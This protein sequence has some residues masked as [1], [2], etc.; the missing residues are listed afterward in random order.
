MSTSEA[1][2]VAMSYGVREGVWIQRLLNKLL[3]DQAIRR[4]EMLGDQKTHLTLTRDPESQNCTKHIDVIYH[5]VR[6][7]VENRELAIE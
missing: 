4:I 7:L 5:H 6:E 2:Y 1:E 3:P